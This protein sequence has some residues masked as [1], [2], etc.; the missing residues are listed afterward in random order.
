MRTSKEKNGQWLA[1]GG[2][3]GRRPTMPVGSCPLNHAATWTP[4]PLA[5]PPPHLQL[6][7]DAPCPVP[8]HCLSSCLPAPLRNSLPPTLGLF[9][10]IIKWHFRV[11]KLKSCDWGPQKKWE[12]LSGFELE[13]TRDPKY[14]SESYNNRKFEGGDRY[15]TLWGR[16]MD[17]I[18]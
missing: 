3:E 12:W 2:A 11:Q 16:V 5:L 13:V 8:H 7:T 14:S 1:Q 15:C 9:M 18:F 6:N 4:A 17:S 10:L